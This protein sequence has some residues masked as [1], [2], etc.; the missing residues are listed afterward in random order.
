M[1]NTL[2]LLLMPLLVGCQ[3]ETQL[4]KLGE[5]ELLERIVSGNMPEP[6]SD[7]VTIQTTDGTVISLDSLKKLENIGQYAEDFYT[8]PNGNIWKV[9]VRKKTAADDAFMRKVARALQAETAPEVR[10]VDVDCGNIGPLLDEV[11]RSDQAMRQEG[12]SIDLQQ[13]HRNLEVVVS[14][15][16]QCG[17]PTR[18]EVSAEQ[19][20]AIW[21]ALQHAPPPWQSKYIP[22]LEKSA[23]RG[24]IAWSIIALMK[25]RAL[26]DEGKPQVYGTQILNGQLYELEAPAYVDQRRAEVGLGPLKTYLQRYGLTFDV[27]QKKR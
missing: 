27:E 6:E 3:T 26:M 5:E 2:L 22:L 13:D 19:L 9:V 24:D 15:I 14:L 11:L 8:G 7:S 12:S 20:S 23:E 4:K 10:Q 18:Q 25:D 16:E 21:L 17:M 1:R